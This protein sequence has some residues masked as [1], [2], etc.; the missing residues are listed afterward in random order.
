MSMLH[1]LHCSTHS[2]QVDTLYV[3]WDSYGLVEQSRFTEVFPYLYEV[4]SHLAVLVGM[5][6]VLARRRAGWLLALGLVGGGTGA[7][8]LREL[9]FMR[10]PGDSNLWPAPMELFLWLDVAQVA[11]AVVCGIAALVMLLRLPRQSSPAARA[12]SES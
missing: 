9:R 1:I 11:L 6:V 10:A 12:G 5:V 2:L 3:G 8:R 4:V 7:E